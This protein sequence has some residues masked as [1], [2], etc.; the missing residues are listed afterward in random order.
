VGLLERFFKNYGP[1]DNAGFKIQLVTERG[2]GFYAWNG[3]L[4]KS[5]IIRACIRPKVRAMGKLIA[6]HIRDSTDGI[7][8]NPEAYMRMLLEEPNPY[9]T[10]QMM[11][12]KLTT[13][14]M[15]NNNAFALIIRDDYGYPVQIYPIPCQ[16]AEVIYSDSGE[17]LLKFI[18]PN[19]KTPTFAYSD[20]I[21]LRRD[22]YNNDIF[23][24]LPIDVLEPVMEIVSTTDQGIVKAIQNSNIIKWLLKFKSTTRPEDIKVHVKDFIDSYMSMDSGSGGAAGVDSKYDLEPVK[25]ES[26]VPNALQMDRTIMRLMNFFNTN[27]AII[28]SKWDENGWTAYY[29]AE[30]E[31]DAMQ[32][33]G[34]YTRKLF[35]RK[36]R[37]FGNK[38][39]FV[40]SNL[41][42]ASMSTKLQLMQM[43]D[44]GAMTP[45]EW[46]EILNM[47][48]VEGG[49]KP[50]RR[51]D[52][53][54][55]S[56]T[57]GGD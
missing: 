44:R 21:H 56:E 50:I 5:D 30:I 52:T 24:E 41:Q 48:P 39:I 47:G 29:E 14:L 36:E 11:Q 4:Y 57:K 55:V 16:A 43:V 35:T 23:G 37:G 53:A 54:V 40:A 20:I 6:K 8:I 22:F 27:E 12:E 31:P 25:P 19:G 34:E 32:L 49:D 10:G 28:Q 51:L 9:M 45:N 17:I 38:I 1:T 26:Y 33:S 3:K 2:N 15:L 42:Y 46:R 18:M 13:Q 7:K